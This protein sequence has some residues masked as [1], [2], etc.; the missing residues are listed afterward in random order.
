MWYTAQVAGVQVQL[1][2]NVVSRHGGQRI[3]REVVGRLP[4]SAILEIPRGIV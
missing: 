1:I 4:T 2:H 3:S